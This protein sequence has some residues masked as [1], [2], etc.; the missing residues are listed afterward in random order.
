MAHGD[1]IVFAGGMCSGK[2][3]RLI[4]KLERELIGRRKVMVFKPAIDTRTGPTYVASRAGRRIS[5]YTVAKASEMLD[6]VA[7]AE[8]VGIDETQ[9]FDET[10]VSVVETLIG[11]GIHVVVAGLDM[12]FR[13]EP[14]DHVAKLMATADKVVK[15]S[16]VCIRCGKKAHHSQRLINGEPAPYDAP[17]IAVGGEELYEARCRD[18]FVMKRPEKS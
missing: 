15:L 6:L 8:F 14:F 18:C 17:R 7:E 1:L 3:D 2:S 10:L 9:F 13:G 4:G 12:D 5:A 11:R 16:A